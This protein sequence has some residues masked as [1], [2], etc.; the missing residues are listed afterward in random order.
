MATTQ[1]RL[2]LAAFVAEVHRLA[3]GQPLTVTEAR[4][5]FR[6]PKCLADV[7]RRSGLLVDPRRRR[8]LEQLLAA[9]EPTHG[10]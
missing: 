5:Y 7:V 8:R 6:N 3:T 1:A 9:K 4:G 2:S 10:L